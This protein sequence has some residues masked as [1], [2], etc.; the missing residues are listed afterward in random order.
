MTRS[1]VST[2]LPALGYSRR[3]TAVTSEHTTSDPEVA[4]KHLGRCAHVLADG[5]GT[6]SLGI[7]VGLTVAPS[8]FGRIL[9]LDA[10]PRRARAIGTLDVVLGTSILTSGRVWPGR[11]WHALTARL[12][13]HVAIAN[14]YRRLGN[15]RGKQAIGGLFVVDGIATALMYRQE[16]RAI[17]STRRRRHRAGRDSADK[18]VH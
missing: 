13:L 8:R 1:Y 12:A 15:R 18:L 6:T 16:G 4:R 5:I 2:S 10:V 11:R 3:R 7:G 17:A 9:G 14:E